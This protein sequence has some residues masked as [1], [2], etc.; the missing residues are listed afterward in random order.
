MRLLTLGTTARKSKVC[1][2]AAYVYYAYH[3]YYAY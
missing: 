3:T 1:I 2:H